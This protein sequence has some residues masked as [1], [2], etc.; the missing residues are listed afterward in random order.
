MF[1]LGK[2]SAEQISDMLLLEIDHYRKTVCDGSLY[3]GQILGALSMVQAH[4]SKELINGIEKRDLE[5][6]HE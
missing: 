5:T 4:F 6:S 2:G 3:I 1:E